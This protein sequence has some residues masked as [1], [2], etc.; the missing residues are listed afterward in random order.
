MYELQEGEY[1][2]SHWCMYL[3]TG[4]AHPMTLTHIHH[5]LKY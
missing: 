2:V 1:F 3:L 5:E 4:L